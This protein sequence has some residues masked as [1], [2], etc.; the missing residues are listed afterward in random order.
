MPTNDFSEFLVPLPAT[1]GAVIP[2]GGFV[3]FNINVGA[4]G[5]SDL[6]FTDA[7]G[8]LVAHIPHSTATPGTVFIRNQ[9]FGSLSVTGTAGWTA[10]LGLAN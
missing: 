7:N 4:V 2:Y 1:D 5:S 6:V 10:S 3:L 9:F 8:H